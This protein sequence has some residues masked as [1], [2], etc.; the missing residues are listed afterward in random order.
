VPVLLKKY[1]SPG[2]DQIPAELI[3]AGGETLQSEIHK[4]INCIW[5]KD[6]LPDQRKESI[7]VLIY[8]KGDKT[9]CGN[10]QGTSL[11]STTYKIVSNILLS[12]LSPHV[13]EIIGDNQCGFRR[14]ISNT[15]QIFCI[16]QIL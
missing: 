10:Y 9:D 16:H 2:S 13:D 8:T 14:N 1:I 7:I 15:D 6:E 12:R 5:S 4:L 11:L 3:Q